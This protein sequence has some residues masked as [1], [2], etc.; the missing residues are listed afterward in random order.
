MC[1]WLSRTIKY[2]WSLVYTY[3]TRALYVADHMCW[4][5]KCIVK[6]NASWE[7]RDEQ[8]ALLSTLDIILVLSLRTS[9]CYY[10]SSAWRMCRASFHF[11]PVLPEVCY[12]NIMLRLI[13]FLGI[14]KQPIIFSIP[15][16]G[17]LHI[18]AFIKISMQQ[19]EISKKHISSIRN[20]N[21]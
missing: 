16:R 1:A 5:G 6:V 2:T 18:F 20:R 8:L 11:F 12:C 17:S 19:Y 7:G 21:D 9:S 14:Y 4:T 3:K 15:A 10:L 13:F